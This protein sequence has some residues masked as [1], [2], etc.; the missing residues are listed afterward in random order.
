MNDFKSQ[1]LTFTFSTKWG[2]STFWMYCRIKWYNGLWIR[3]EA[4]HHGR[5]RGDTN[6]AP[7]LWKLSYLWRRMWR[8][9]LRKLWVLPGRMHRGNQNHKIQGIHTELETY[10]WAPPGACRHKSLTQVRAGRRA[11]PRCVQVLS[12]T[13][14]RGRK[15][16]PRV[17]RV[18]LHPGACM[19]IEPHPGACR[20]WASPRCVN[21]E[22]YPE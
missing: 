1:K 2:V 18:E 15:G 22:D 4:D 21:V 3:S 14:E 17:D 16:L 6:Q 11:S 8:R 5:P 20:Y 10:Y 9:S 7:S 19:Q 12:A 13:Q